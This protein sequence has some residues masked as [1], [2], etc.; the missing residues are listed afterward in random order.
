MSTG[1][2][3]KRSAPP[4]LHDV[5]AD[6]R[7]GLVG[8]RARTRQGH[9][10]GGHRSRRPGAGR[11]PGVRL[12]V[13]P[14]WTPAFSQIAGCVCDTGGALS[15][16]AIVSR[17]YRIPAVCATGARDDGDPHRRHPRGRRHRR[18]RP[19]PRARLARW[20]DDASPRRADPRR[21]RGCRCNE[22]PLASTA[23][24]SWR[25]A[26]R[27]T[28]R[29]ARRGRVDETVDLDGAWVVPG[30][31]DTHPHLLH[32]SVAPSRAWPTCRDAT[33][34]ADIVAAIAADRVRAGRPASG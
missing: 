18:N 25:S 32:F 1:G 26:T 15:H 34:H 19:H 9:H 8:R 3:S 30:L 11:D 7:P 21:L 2:C 14:N 23:D 17:E 12:H 24:E 27:S 5:G 16:T 31:I 22:S 29:R 28:S 10:V 13:T 20:L 6:R 33:D 4:M